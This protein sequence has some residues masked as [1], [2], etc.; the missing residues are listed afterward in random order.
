MTTFLYPTF[1]RVFKNVEVLIA[2]MRLIKH[3]SARLELTFSGEENGYAR[4]MARSAAGLSSV[5]FIGPQKHSDLMA[6]LPMYD[7]LVFPSKLETW[8]LPMSEFR[9]L[10]KPIFASNL[11]F[12]H[13]TLS[14]Y[15]HACFF[16]PN[17][18]VRLAGLLRDFAMDGRFVPTPVVIDYAQPFAAN[19][20]E[21]YRLIGIE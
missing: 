14:G 18:P 1:P 8:G 6:S 7:A 15:K 13:E 12:A 3:D 11:P 16:D 9:D 2:A 21:L 10:G 20:T 19:W 17:D 4:E 5:H